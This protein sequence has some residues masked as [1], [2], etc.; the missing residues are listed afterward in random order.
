MFSLEDIEKFQEVIANYKKEV[1]E[2]GEGI[3]L[4]RLSQMFVDYPTLTKIVFTAF[5]PYFNDG[6]ECVF[7]SNHGYADFTCNVGKYEGED[8]IIE[9][10]EY[11]ID[12]EY[13]KQWENMQASLNTYMEPFDDGVTLEII[14]GPHAQL[15]IERDKITVEEY[16]DHD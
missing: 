6:D 3:L 1:R 4:A 7:S 12:A 10:G 2:K 15:T 14:T 16:T 11:D 13:E 5:V 8:M 9:G